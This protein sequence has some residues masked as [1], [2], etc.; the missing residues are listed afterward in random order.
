MVYSH[1]ELLLKLPGRLQHTQKI[2]LMPIDKNAQLL[3]EKLSQQNA[4]TLI[5]NRV[6]MQ[7]VHILQWKLF[8]HH[9][10]K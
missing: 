6:N 5:R 9:T 4:I 7:W 10:K 3:F 1:E 2:V 8:S